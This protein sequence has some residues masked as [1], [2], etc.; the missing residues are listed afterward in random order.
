M[1]PPRLEGGELRIE[2]QRA[3]SAAKGKHLRRGRRKGVML[4]PSAR[5]VH[6]GGVSPCAGCGEERPFH[7]GGSGRRGSLL[8][9]TTPARPSANAMMDITSPSKEGMK[10]YRDKETRDHTPPNAGVM[11]LNGNKK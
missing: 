9:T 10:V 2:L 5:S 1:C 8:A 11:H 6:A 4:P 3:Y 7:S